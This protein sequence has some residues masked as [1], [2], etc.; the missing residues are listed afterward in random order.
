[1]RGKLFAFTLVAAVA[2][3]A[4][5]AAAAA[6]PVPAKPGWLPPE[7][8]AGQLDIFAKGQAVIVELS[9]AGDGTV[10]RQFAV[11]VSDAAG[12]FPRPFHSAAARVVSWTGHL[13]VIAEAESRAYHFSVAGFDPPDLSKEDVRGHRVE[14]PSLASTYSVTRIAGA[15]AII[16]NTPAGGRSLAM[17][18]GPVLGASFLTDLDYQDYGSGG[19]SGSCGSS[20]TQNCADGSTC[21]VACSAPRCAHC[22][23]PASCSCS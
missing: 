11:E 19:G 5:A 4:G 6:L 9:A 8:L 22:S 16:S 15:Q 12:W 7:H 20:C 21:S 18:P 13:V 1:M 14:S 23:C 3:S 10:D 2:V 17:R